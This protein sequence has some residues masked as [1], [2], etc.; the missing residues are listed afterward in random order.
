M[1]ITKADMAAMGTAVLSFFNLIPWANIAAFLT[2]IYLVIRIV[3][4]LVR[5]DTR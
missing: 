5:R 3:V 4:T 2:C 1:H